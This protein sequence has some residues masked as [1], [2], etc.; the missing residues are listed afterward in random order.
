MANEEVEKENEN[1]NYSVRSDMQ[2]AP[3]AGLFPPE[4]RRKTLRG[5]WAACCSF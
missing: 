3:A 4:K 5:P 1:L 2:E